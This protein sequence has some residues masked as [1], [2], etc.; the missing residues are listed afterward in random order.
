M[1]K[2][3]H[4]EG[5]IWTSSAHAIGHGVNVFGVMGHGIAVQF[6]TRF[7]E[8]YQKYREQCLNF[9]LSPGD[10]FAWQVKGRIVFNIASQNRPGKD[11][12]IEWLRGGVET[13]L[14]TCD[15][16]NIPTLALPRIGSGIGGLDADEVEKV[17]TELAEK[18]TT[19]IELWTWKA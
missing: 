15:T 13:A 11:A 14:R 17:L 19:D 1:T 5:D 3:I 4:K 12:R 18:H 16:L 8:M 2:L 7:P 10:V 6:R 9:K